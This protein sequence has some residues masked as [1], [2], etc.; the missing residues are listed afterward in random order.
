MGS[1]NFLQWNNASANQENDAA[2]AA[3]SLRT[4]GAATNAPFPSPTANKLFY[5]V[6]TAIAA[7]MQAMANKGYVVSDANLTTLIAVLANIRTIADGYPL[8]TDLLTATTSGSISVS[9]AFPQ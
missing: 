7:L 2:Y 6:S 3:D 4:G 5:Q 9:T 1:T 8:P